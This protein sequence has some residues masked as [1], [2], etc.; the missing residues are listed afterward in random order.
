MEWVADGSQESIRK[1]KFHATRKM[2]M[3]KKEAMK[4]I[5]RIYTQTMRFN[6]GADDLLSNHESPGAHT[7]SSILMD[8]NVTLECTIRGRMNFNWF[9][10][11]SFVAMNELSD[12]DY[13]VVPRVD[14]PL[15][16]AQT[17][18]MDYR[19]ILHGVIRTVE[20]KLDG[21]PWRNQDVNGKLVITQS[22]ANAL[23]HKDLFEPIGINFNQACENLLNIF[24]KTIVMDEVQEMPNFR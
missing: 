19:L 6:M 20:L 3:S 14:S 13:E 23:K 8:H 16:L 17:E 24:G 10:G 18:E 7:F 1:A 5:T 9:N 2:G 11:R 12:V 22:T 15:L 21:Q 4:V